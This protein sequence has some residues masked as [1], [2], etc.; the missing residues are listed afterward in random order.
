MVTP[1]KNN[2]CI[3]PFSQLTISPSGQY[4]PCPEI[5]ARLE[6]DYDVD[7]FK[8]WNSSIME[9][10]R[11]S[12]LNNE[13]HSACDRCWQQE[14]LGKTS[15]RKNLFVQ[16]ISGGAKFKK[17]EL[18][19]WLTETHKQ[20]PKQINL[21]VGNKCNLRCRYCRADS[22]VTYN[23]E[24]KV[25]A[26]K[27]QDPR[28]ARLYFNEKIKPMEFTP[29][30]IEQI[31]NLSKNL[32]RLEFYGGEP[33]LD[34]PTF[35]L[36]EKYV[37]SGQS[38]NITLFYNTNGVNE[39]TDRH[40]EIWN[41][42]NSIEFNLSIDDIDDRYHYIRHPALWEDF[43]NN[44][45]QIRNFNWTIP[46]QTT[47]IT[48]VGNL[49]VLYVPEI[50]ERLESLDLKVFL[51]TIHGPDWYD[52]RYLPMPIKEK[53]TNK[54]AKYKN[55]SQID[56]ILKYL[57]HDENLSHWEDFKFWTKTKDEYR[58]ENFSQVYPE[59]YEIIKGYDDFYG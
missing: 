22:S 48:T 16:N 20:G 11:T 3:A 1:V 57:K 43:I 35:S 7:P 44:L 53:I 54:L 51:N 14:E 46:L 40:F 26:T 17:G 50:I 30:Q 23:I 42:F 13:K 10:L 34:K 18:T 38:K 32:T 6:Q 4:S 58:K 2:F 21:I 5:G 37:A 29:A 9:E 59:F 31:F 56:F 12:F 41:K 49:N 39:I 33:L 24:G 15:L 28:Q 19:T 8:M 55:L 45:N 52:M 36:L 27:T 47:A 25:Y